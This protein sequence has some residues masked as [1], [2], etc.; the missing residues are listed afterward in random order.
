MSHKLIFFSGKFYNCMMNIQDNEV[1]VVGGRPGQ[2][3]DKWDDKTFVYS[4]EKNATTIAEDGKWIGT[5][6]HRII[7]LLTLFDPI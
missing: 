2:F 6:I 3:F 5:S 7:I 4:W 1:M